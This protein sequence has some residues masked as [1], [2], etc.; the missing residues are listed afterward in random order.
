MCIRDSLTTGH[1]F[2]INSIDESKELRYWICLSPACDM[3]PDQKKSPGLTDCIPFVAVLLH[4][5]AENN[6]LMKATDNIFLFLKI[7]EKIETFSIYKDGVNTNNPDWEQKF[8][9]NKGRFNDNN[10]LELGSIQEKDD[11]LTAAWVKAT[12]IAQLRSEYALNL[13]QRIGALLSR[14]GLGINFRRRQ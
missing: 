13:L 14:P 6:A 2:R 9:R 4:R 5:V 11:E 8:A 3:V 12:V 10:G 1:V 7:D